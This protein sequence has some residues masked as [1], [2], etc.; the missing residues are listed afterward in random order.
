V[1]D[2]YLLVDEPQILTIRGILALDRM[3]VRLCCRVLLTCLV[4]SGVDYLEWK[5]VL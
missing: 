4:D 3:R 5:R 2:G 1:A